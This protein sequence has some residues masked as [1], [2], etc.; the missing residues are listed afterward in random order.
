VF[1]LFNKKKDPSRRP[2]HNVPGR[3]SATFSYYAGEAPRK[4]DSVRA[5]QSDSKRQVFFRR[6]RLMPT[7]I[8]LLVIG[9][10]VVYGTTLSTVPNVR[11]V[12]GS[13]PYRTV[14]AYAGGIETVLNS[15]FLNRSKLTIN[16]TSTAAKITQIYPEVDVATI[17]LPIIGRRPTINMHVRQPALMLT[18]ATNAFVVD[19]AG[20]VVAETRQLPSSVLDDLMTAQDQSGLNL[21]VG[22]QAVTSETVSFLTSLKAQLEAKQLRIDHLVLI[23][24]GYEADVYL[25]DIAY[26]IK[27]DS[28]G[29]A[30][31]QVGAFLAARSNGASPEEYMD[32]RV[33]EKVFYK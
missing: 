23:G 17:S 32:V 30:R 29:D 3:P 31:L 6:L 28:S 27:T 24:G 19:D 33:E 9:L 25:K 18:T 15:S 8:A 26:F 22:D 7:V 21:R 11:F 5:R 4:Q 1:R 14:Q 20:K 13:S 12:G 2:R 10:S 16:T